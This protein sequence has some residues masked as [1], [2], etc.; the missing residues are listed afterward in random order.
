MK[1]S[2]LIVLNLVNIVNSNMI[3]PPS[4]IKNYSTFMD[5]TFNYSNNSLI[6]T[7][8]SISADDCSNTCNVNN[9]CTG[10]NYYPEINSKNFKSKCELGNSKYNHSLLEKNFNCAFYIK[11]INDCS[12]D[13]HYMIG[14]YVCIGI[15]LLILSCCIISNCC[16]KKNRNSYNQL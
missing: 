14:L 8:R 5:Q 2:I 12:S 16:C 9:N 7:I 1:N 15:V 13:S 11:S 4:C 10:F 3:T 6:S